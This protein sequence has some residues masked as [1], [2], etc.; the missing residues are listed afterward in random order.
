MAETVRRLLVAHRRTAFVALLFVFL[1]VFMTWPL[2]VN[3]SHSVI[4]WMGDNFYFVWLIGWFQRSLLVLHRSPI[5]VPLLNFPEG[6]NLAYSEMAPAMVLVAL[7]FS[8]VGGPVLG[9]NA[10]LLV[11]FVLSALGVYLWVRHLTGDTTAAVVAG[12]I[13]AFC[14]FR[15]SHMLGHLQLM[16]TQWF[17]FYFMSLTGL[18][19]RGPKR[20]RHVVS[21]AVFLSLIALTSQYYLYMA[22]VLTLLYVGCCWWFLDRELVRRRE[23]WK[24]LGAALLL[25]LPVVVMS[26]LPYVTLAK[27]RKSLSRPLEGVRIWSASPTDFFLPSARQLFWGRVSGT[28]I[29]GRGWVEYTLYVGVVALLL[30]GAALA[31]RRRLEPAARRLTSAL[32]GTGLGA[33]VLALGT[34]L[35]WMGRPVVAALPGFLQRLSPVPDGALPLPGYL[36]FRYLP[37]YDGMRVWMRYGIFVSLFVSVLAGMGAAT[38]LRSRSRQVSLFAGVVLLAAVSADFF[39]A[40]RSLTRVQGRSVDAWL[41][42]QEGPGAVAQFPASQLARPEQGYYASLNGKPFVG[43]FFTGYPPAQ[44]RRI[45][46]I[47]QSFPDD[48][49]TSL[50]RELGVRWVVV[51]SARY[52]DFED[53]SRRIEAQGLHA[54]GSFDGEYV[55]ELR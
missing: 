14:P 20:R 47:L 26:V 1:T 53:V 55:W 28:E 25:A 15:T 32:A 48:R 38:L 5:S 8:L 52:A 3:M 11:S 23:S 46:G 50:L 9:Y 21:A 37:F 27:E 19:E 35:H 30:A 54:A 13:F 31:L 41:A 45:Y 39:P 36:L 16:G 33:F 43:G 34:D 18:F 29:E 10:S 2:A 17:P 49:S 42:S 4:G 40:F 7:P 6:W 51:D 12:A 24:G 22:L 44:F